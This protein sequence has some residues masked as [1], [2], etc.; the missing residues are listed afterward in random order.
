ML[1]HQCPVVVR[2]PSV[3]PTLQINYWHCSRVG[4]HRHLLMFTLTCG[5]FGSMSMPSGSIDWIKCQSLAQRHYEHV[6]C[7]CNKDVPLYVEV[8]SW[9]SRVRPGGL[10][11]SKFVHFLPMVS[12]KH[13]SSKT[14]E[15][16]RNNQN[17]HWT[18][19]KSSYY[20]REVDGQNGK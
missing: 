17:M 2:W 4:Y 14:L 9:P 11:L 12:Y 10:D 16:I 3:S 8:S 15:L 19:C 13:N 5:S 20:S 6:T 1:L 18:W 7:S